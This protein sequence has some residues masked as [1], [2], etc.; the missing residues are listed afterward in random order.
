MGF[1]NSPHISEKITNLEL[2]LQD[3]SFSNPVTCGWVL[4]TLSR[5]PLASVSSL[6]VSMHQRM[7]PLNWP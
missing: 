1:L 6:T 7:E 5:I 4:E 2:L 3:P